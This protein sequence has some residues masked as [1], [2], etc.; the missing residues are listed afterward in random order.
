[1]AVGLEKDT[2]VLAGDMVTVR[3]THVMTHDN[4]GAVLPK[5]RAIGAE[6]V[7]DPAQPVFALDHNVQDRSEANLEKYAR[8]KAF[9]DEQ[10][11]VFHPAGAG[12]GHQLMIENG[13]VHPGSL[14]VASDSHSNMYGAVAAVG[15]PVVRTDA[16][17]IWATGVTW[18]QVPRTVKVVLEGELRPGVVGKDVILT[19]CGLYNSGEV[20]NAAVEFHGAG[21]AT[22]SMDDRMTISNMTTEWGALVGWFP[23]DRRTSHYL[24]GRAAMLD[25]LEI[26]DRLTGAM[27]DAWDESPPAPDPDAGYAAEIVLDLGR[28]S[29]HVAG[30]HLV[31]VTRPVAEMAKERKR[32]HKAYLLSCVNSRYSDLAQA[33]TVLDGKKVAD[34]V[35]LYVA[36]ASAGV[37]QEA[38]GHG[39]WA[40]LEA[41]GATMLPP[42]CGACIGLGIGLL[43]PGEVGISATNR[44][45]KGRMGSPDAEAYL[46]SPAVVAASAVAGYITGP[47][48]LG[49]SV[50]EACF[51]DLGWTPPVR[52]VSIMDGFPEAL[53]GRVLLM[54]VDNLNT[55]GIYGKDVTYLDHLTPDEMAGHAMAN[56]DRSFQEIA[57]DGDVIVAGKNFGTGSS[58][59]Q[60][61]T[62]LKFRGIRM[63]IA[64]SFSQTYLRNAFNNA[65]IC[66]ESPALAD[67][68]RA[69]FTAAA[70]AGDKTIPAGTLKVDF[71]RAVATWN[72]GD[73]Q[74]S[75]VG[76]AA[77]ELILAGGLEALTRER[78]AG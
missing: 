61:A 41:A 59:E 53:E 71:K 46:A 77:Q 67:A 54:P 30:P 44:N 5:F 20:L 21:V 56:Y 12:I 19:L 73:Y 24:R 45:F 58:R 74:L 10:G 1:H 78:I 49:S 14:V 36:A 42:G 6:R 26:P 76:P 75:P 27:I 40:T 62:A 16:A 11:I 63:V 23:W 13:F 9:A 68:V 28:V 34:G 32:I 43:Q 37:Q 72:G 48:D 57:A 50:P 52:E 70:D 4:T 25:A 15:T 65:F 33:A 38:E 55:D 8:I 17:A 51:T 22:L 29:P 18:W 31:G 7:A 39:V 47:E 66:I 64:A 69:A 35:E 3:P 60:A 2:E